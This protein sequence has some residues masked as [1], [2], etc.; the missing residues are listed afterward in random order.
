MRAKG[1]RSTMNPAH[2]IRVDLVRLLGATER[3]LAAGEPSADGS[4]K[5]WPRFC[6]VCEFDRLPR[7]TH[8]AKLCKMMRLLQHDRDKGEMIG[9]PDLVGHAGCYRPWLET[10]LRGSSVST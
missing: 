2:K 7:N 4:W 9:I 1:T 6:Q 5:H 10:W 3:L 8:P